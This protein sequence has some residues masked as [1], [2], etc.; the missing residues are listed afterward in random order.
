MK[1]PLCLKP[2][3]VYSFTPIS[4]AVMCTAPQPFARASSTTL[5]SNSFAIPIL[6]YS[7]SVYMLESRPSFPVGQ[8]KYGGLSTKDMP[9]VPTIFSPSIASH[10]TKDPSAIC[11]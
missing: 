4:D 9:L 1:F 10:E 2:Y 11:L 5:W 7:G 3:A 8:V 6:L